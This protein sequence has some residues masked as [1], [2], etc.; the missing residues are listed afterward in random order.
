MPKNLE[1]YTL[2]EKLAIGFLVMLLIMMAA[3]AVW[4]EDRAPMQPAPPSSELS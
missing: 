1:P 4:Q 2:G 3:S